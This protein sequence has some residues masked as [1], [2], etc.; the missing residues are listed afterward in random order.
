MREQIRRL[1]KFAVLAVA[2]ASAAA[3]GSKLDGATGYGVALWL[4]VGL[5]LAVLVWWGYRSLKASNATLQRRESQLAEAQALTHVGSFEWEVA[6][7]V[8]TWTDELYRIYGLTPE[9]FR[10]SYEGFLERIHPDDR[11]SVSA[12]LQEAFQSPKP[13]SFE[14]RIIRPDGE[15]R[16]LYSRAQV[17]FDKHGKPVLLR[18]SCQ[19]VTE[20]KKA[21]EALEKAYEE[22]EG[23]IQERTAQLVQANEK[24]R[25][26]QARLSGILHTAP[27]CIISM[28]HEGKLVDINPAGEKTFGVRRD[29]VVGKVLS[30]LFI[31]P[32][33]REAHRKGLERFLATKESSIIGKRVEFPALRADGS[34]FPAEIVVTCVSDSQPPLFTAHLRDISER[35][36]IDEERSRLIKQWE[37]AAHARDAFIS[38]AAH[39][40]RTP[41]SALQLQV[42]LMKRS[43]TPILESAGLTPKLDTIGRQVERLS[44]L[45]DNL[46]DVS[47]V[48]AGRLQLEMEELDLASVVREVL[49]RFATQA[50]QVQSRLNV[51]V[52]ES[53]RGFWDRLRL[54]QV[55][56]NLLGNALKYGAGRPV[57]VVLESSDG[58]ACL[59]VRDQGIGISPEDQ[60]RIFER[61]ERVVSSRHYGGLGLGL[62]ITR[63]IVEAMGGTIRVTS[64]PGAGSTFRVELPKRPAALTLAPRSVLVVEDDSDVLES[65]CET[66]RLAGFSVVAAINGQEALTNLRR[67]AEQ[68]SIVLLDLMMP[69]MNGWQFLEEKKRDPR[70]ASIPVVVLSADA[71]LAHSSYELGPVEYLRKPVDVETLVSVVERHREASAAGTSST[72]ARPAGRS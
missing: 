9:S 62:W 47:R 14:E 22:L 19:D 41:L 59:S 1:A 6:T 67:H 63:Q 26:S 52:P 49:E 65:I 3:L 27:D 57:D 25:M 18:G 42:D 64:A 51:E 32:Q 54:E 56:T 46:L 58:M 29:E 5:T 2:F 24:L 71:S 10:A 61:F 68:T 66:L 40:L 53:L 33:L 72:S 37:E 44:K 50:H 34:E 35:R 21:Q 39:E 11:A 23:R 30:A 4:A 55:V 38:I 15:I 12:K 31:P 13:I 8:V 28:D 17:L 45:V 60:L 48:A 43:S 69:V 20:Q 7:N 36:R 16:R 70:L